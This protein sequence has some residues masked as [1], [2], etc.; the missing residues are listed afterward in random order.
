M[1]RIR[2]WCFASCWL[3]SLR[4]WEKT[5]RPLHCTLPITRS[6]Q[7]G[8]TLSRES[9]NC[10]GILSV[11]EVGWLKTAQGWI[12]MEPV[13]Y[14][15]LFA[16]WKVGVASSNIQFFLGFRDFQSY[17]SSYF[18]IL[19]LTIKKNGLYKALNITQ[20]PTWFIIL[21]RNRSYKKIA[22]YWKQDN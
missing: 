8:L 10:T 3:V 14:L 2:D 7:P 1:L 15:A 20:H 17:M 13:V 5:H 9:V 21:F 4:K 19:L 22:H 16:P 6:S 18:E 12:W 11:L